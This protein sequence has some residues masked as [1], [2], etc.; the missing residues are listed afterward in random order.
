M[1][2]LNILHLIEFYKKQERILSNSQYFNQ[3]LKNKIANWYVYFYHCLKSEKIVTKILLIKEVIRL[4][5][6]IPFYSTKKMRFLRTMFG[7]NV[8]VYIWVVYSDLLN[9]LKY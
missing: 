3:D 6:K 7:T 2:S 8:S 1:S 4:N 9:Y 5:P